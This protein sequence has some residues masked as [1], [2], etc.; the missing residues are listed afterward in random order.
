MFAKGHYFLPLKHSG[1]YLCEQNPVKQWVITIA[2]C[3]MPRGPEQQTH[4][5][6]QHVNT[7]TNTCFDLPDLTEAL[8]SKRCSNC[9]KRW[10]E[11]DSNMILIF[12]SWIF[13]VS[14]CQ[15]AQSMLAHMKNAN[16]ENDFECIGNVCGTLKKA[17]TGRMEEQMKENMVWY[18]VE[19]WS[20]HIQNKKMHNCFLTMW[21]WIR[22]NFSFYVRITK[23]ISIC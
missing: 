15:M 9:S 7:L 22:S 11:H 23:F 21:I 19:N 13:P 6:F 20:L 3:R 12:K 5:P 4:V 2:R 14:D 10:R 18:I 1:F 8:R 16:T 17:Q